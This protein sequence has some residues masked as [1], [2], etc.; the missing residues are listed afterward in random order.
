MLHI[1]MLKKSGSFDIIDDIMKYVTLVQS[2]KIVGNVSHAVS[3]SGTWIFDKNYKNHF[4]WENNHWILFVL[5]LIRIIFILNPRRFIMQF[6]VSTQQQVSKFLCN[7][8]GLI[9]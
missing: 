9:F 3:I 1:Q 4:H 7:M 8:I 6:N 2:M 5:F